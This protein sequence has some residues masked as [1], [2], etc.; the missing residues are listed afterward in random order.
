MNHANNSYHNIIVWL[1]SNN[2]K[3]DLCGAK[4]W[5]VETEWGFLNRETDYRAGVAKSSVFGRR[6]AVGRLPRRPLVLCKK[7]NN[8]ILFTAFGFLTA[9]NQR[10]LSRRA[11]TINYLTYQAF[12]LVWNEFRYELEIYYI[13]SSCRE[14]QAVLITYNVL[15]TITSNYCTIMVIEVNSLS[16]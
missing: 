7:Q 11:I 12:H 1:M 13:V 15:W 16:R 5:L 6:T 14:S 3:L 9:V 4:W 2:V 8:Y 10:S